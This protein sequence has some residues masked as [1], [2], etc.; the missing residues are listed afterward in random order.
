MK[1]G[2]SNAKVYCD[3][4]NN[5]RQPLCGQG[6]LGIVDNFYY[7]DD[8]FTNIQ[9]DSGINIDSNNLSNIDLVGRLNSYNN[10]NYPNGWY[11][12][13]SDNNQNPI[14]VH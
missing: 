6:S 8:G 7:K 2:Y 14:F 4:K 11:K 12:W 13:I 9:F 3:F 10:G 1:N 5:R